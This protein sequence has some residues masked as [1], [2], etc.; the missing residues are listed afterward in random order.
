MSQANTDYGT[1]LQR[2]GTTIAE[3]VKISPPEI[4]QE[5]V[6]VTNHSSPSGYREYIPGGLKEMAEFSADINFLPNY[7][8]HTVISGIMHDVVSG[9]SQSYSL[10][11]PTTPVVTWTFNALTTRFALADM[12]AENPDNLSATITLRPTGAPTLA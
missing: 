1:L 8:Q 3:V 4:I 12:D 11:F 10:V 9:I 5:A 2:A 7:G 6:E